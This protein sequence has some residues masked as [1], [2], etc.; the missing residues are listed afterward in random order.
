MSV[1]LDRIKRHLAAL[2]DIADRT[3]D[4][5][6]VEAVIALSDAV[7]LAEYSGRQGVFGPHS[8]AFRRRI[9]RAMCLLD[10][11]QIERQH[12][13]RIMVDAAGDLESLLAREVMTSAEPL[14]LDPG[15]LWVGPPAK[16]EK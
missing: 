2:R 3:N 16:G 9:A 1:D 11:V 5:T 4:P 12:D 13:L 8:E 14:R 6:V 7:D 15:M 10:A